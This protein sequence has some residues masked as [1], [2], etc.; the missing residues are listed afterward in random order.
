[1]ARA[2]APLPPTDPARIVA[3]LLCVL[4]GIIGALPLAIEVLLGVGSVQRWAAEQ[5]AALLRG[6][7][8]LVAT[9]DVRVHLLPPRLTVEHLVVPASDGGGPALSVERIRIRPRVFS[10]LAGR[11]D[12]GEVEID[13]PRARLVVN[14]GKLSNVHYQLPKSSGPSRKSKE[15]PF[16]SL[17]VNDA[18]VQLNIDG[19]E[20]DSGQLDLDVF[21]EAGPAFEVMLSTSAASIKRTRRPPGGV[22]G[23]GVEDHDAI[24]R[25]ELRAR[26]EGTEV[27]VRRM[28]LGGVADMDPNSGPMPACTGDPNAPA[29]AYVRL[30]Q[31]RV[32]LRENQQQPYVAGHVALRAPIALASRFAKTPLLGGWLSFA[33]DLRF[34]QTT[35][36]PELR[37]K[38]SGGNLSVAK[39]LITRQV[40]LDLQISREVVK[41]PR[42]EMAFADGQAV[43]TGARVEPLVKGLPISIER[44]ECKRLLFESLMRDL[45]VTPNTIVSWYLTNTTVTNLRG[46]LAPLKFDAD[47]FAENR[48]FEVTDRA[49]HNPARKLMIGVKNATLRGKIGARP[50]ALVFYDTRVEA[51]KASSLFV[52]WVAIGFDNHLALTVGQ[53]SKVHLGD[54][55][56]LVGI[57]VAGEAEVDCTMEGEAGNPLLLGNLKIAN[58][59]FGGFRL[60][61]IKS[62]KV[63]F[64]PLWVEFTEVLAR[65]GT[66]D[67]VSSRAK[68]DFDSNATVRIDARV[69]TENLNLR[70]FIAMWNFDQDPRFD[71]I[72]GFAA[73]DATVKYALGG[74][75]DHCGGGVLRA[76]G[77]LRGRDLDFYGERYESGDGVF[78]FL[79]HDRD[80]TYKGIVLNVP[81]ATLRKG[82][83]VMRGK[84]QMQTG[85]R[86][87][88]EFSAENVPLTKIDSFPQMLRSAEGTAS[89]TGRVSGT[90]DATSALFNATISRVKIGRAY[91]PESSVETRLVPIERPSTIVGT[92]RCG[93]PISAPFDRAEFDRDLAQGVFHTSGQLYG[94][95]VTLNDLTVTR[96][97]KKISRGEIVAN[98]LDLAP[99]LELRPDLT[100]GKELPVGRVT[101]VLKLSEFPNDEPS[102]AKGSLAL[103]A[104]SLTREGI[105]AE[106]LPESQPITFGGQQVDLARL[107]LSVT[108]PRGQKVALDVAGKLDHVG[109]APNI[110][111]RLSLRP[112]P[113]AGLVALFPRVEHAAGSVSGQLHLLGPLAAPRTSGNLELAHGELSVRGVPNSL[114]DIQ[115]ALSFDGNE[116]NITKGSARFGSGDLSF[117]GGAPLNGF[118]LGE[119]RIHVT[120][121]DLSLPLKDGI[122]GT[123]DADLWVAIKPQ[124]DSEE[125]A[126]PRVTGNVMLRSFEY[127]RAVTLAADLNALAQRGKRTEFESYDSSEDTLEF[128][129]TLRAQRPLGIRNEIVEADLVIGPEGLELAGTN[130]RFGLRGTL[131][132]RPGGHV[133]LRRSDFEIQ[134]GSVRFDD[135]TRIAPRVDVTAVTEYRRYSN[136]TSSSQT[137]GNAATPISTSTT[138]SLTGGRWRIRMHAHGDADNLRVELTSDPALPQDDIFLLLTVGVTRAELNQAQSAS[139]GESVALEA[140]GTLTGAD[141][142]VKKAVPIIDEFRFGSAY[143]SRT[144][145]TEPTFTVGK[146]LSDRLRAN[147]TS[148]LSEAREVRSNVE[149]RLSPRVS[150]EG[151]YDNV[152][153][154]SSSSFG[155]LGADI[156][157][158]LEFE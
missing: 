4:F 59:E 39:K 117:S 49:F 62:S 68:L 77:K 8:G 60:G 44:V 149:W 7:L 98:N 148:G 95:M 99:F 131:R 41:V 25:L 143:S 83:G 84:F 114:S 110:D 154:I 28:A 15:S 124:K 90:V 70:D 155:N 116:L 134:E 125:R 136:A 113:V 48:D 71:Q 56:P 111:A 33:G 6:Q 150:V 86:I 138:T 73:A 121:Q 46:T 63:R 127:K 89:G 104:F 34:D 118:A 29:R 130:S 128:D 102:N 57:P 129:V 94:G 119:A 107:G 120:G 14:D 55:N 5:T 137:S 12:A 11:I 3:R 85:A 27:F 42:L 109:T 141:R 91:L 81:E 40:D 79:W 105:K 133:I 87:E 144:G 67:F 54:V 80:A 153:D 96:Q 22:S 23:P 151:S 2:N 47:L 43:L 82:P 10:L 37:G 147:V 72:K 103:K 140:L 145:R 78:D 50:D 36:L 93:Q 75:E 61:D 64:R 9:Y 100:L 45:D 156:R 74:P 32:S 53:G 69:A 88:G 19:I 112:T 65:K 122:Q 92:T 13:S 157:W 146:R 132:V 76:A 16:G 31:L 58:F 152:N 106:L 17:S 20:I 115:I 142:A 158:R 97:R 24:C 51:G 108:T 123:A 26:L 18:R 30:S 126:L 38:V 66:S 139:V 1:M 52:K 135:L 35:R 21:T 101:G